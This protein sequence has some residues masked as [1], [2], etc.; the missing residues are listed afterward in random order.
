MFDFHVTESPHRICPI[1]P[2]CGQRTLIARISPHPD[3]GLVGALL[4]SYECLCGEKIGR[5]EY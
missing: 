5:K 1:C 3:R 2:Q 4:C